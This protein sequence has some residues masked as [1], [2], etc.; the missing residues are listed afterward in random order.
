M[1]EKKLK[2]GILIKDT[3]HSL[4][5]NVA[6]KNIVREIKA[7]INKY[8][9]DIF[10]G[11]EFIFALENRLYNKQ[12]KDNLLKELA[13]PTKNKDTLII[14]GSIVWE[15]GSYFYNTAPIISKGIIN[16]YHKHEKDGYSL[17]FAEA[18]NCKTK[19]YYSGTKPAIVSWR[20]YRIGVEICIDS[21]YRRL[22]SFL[23]EKHR[24]LLDLYFLVSCG[25]QISHADQIPIK[26]LGYGLCSDGEEPTSE[27]LQ[28]DDNNGSKNF[29]KIG[30][31]N[32]EPKREGFLNIYE[33]VMKHA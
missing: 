9:L 8:D 18:K 14:P 2:V 1:L 33:V 30:S 5:G 13:E 7:G 26:N 4:R 22:Y 28:R 27:V 19:K 16:E 11:P 31:I 25:A 32:I 24:P 20:N 29:S 10:L 12:E 21:A 23:Q 17:S 6:S 15:D 3:H